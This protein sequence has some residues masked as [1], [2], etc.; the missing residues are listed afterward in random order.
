[1]PRHWL[2]DSNGKYIDDKTVSFHYDFAI[3][4][5]ELFQKCFNMDILD[6]LKMKA[7]K[8]GHP[9]KQFEPCFYAALKDNGIDFDDDILYMDSVQKLKG[10]FGDTPTYYNFFNPDSGIFHYDDDAFI[11][12]NIHNK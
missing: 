11:S 6:D 1:M 8:N 12:N 2:F 10:E 4:E 3:L 9:S 7:V 5:R